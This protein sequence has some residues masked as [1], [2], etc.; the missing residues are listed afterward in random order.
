ME[1]LL[2]FLAFIL[3]IWYLSVRHSFK[4]AEREEEM[5]R[6]NQLNE[7]QYIRK[8]KEKHMLTAQ[9][10]ANK[11]RRAAENKFEEILVK[12]ET[13]YGSETGAPFVETDINHDTLTVSMDGVVIGGIQ[14]A[15]Q[16]VKDAEKKILELM[17]KFPRI[18]E[19]SVNLNGTAINAIMIGDQTVVENLSIELD[20]ITPEMLKA[21]EDHAFRNFKLFI[22][23]ITNG[24]TFYN[25]ALAAQE[26]V[27]YAKQAHADFVHN[28]NAKRTF[29][30]TGE[31]VEY[32]KAEYPWASFTDVKRAIAQAEKEVEL[33]SKQAKKLGYESQAIVVGEEYTIDISAGR[34]ETSHP[35]RTAALRLGLIIESP[36]I[37]IVDEQLDTNDSL[38]SITL[39]T[40][41]QCVAALKPEKNGLGIYVKTF[42]P[43]NYTE[44]FDKYGLEDELWQ[45]DQD[46][47]LQD[48][49]NQ[50]LWK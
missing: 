32:I 5:H 29:Q 50:D 37:F 21:M 10:E 7:I 38:Y 40:G 47:T 42:M 41:Q 11:A 9:Y 33:F 15:R 35:Q 28:S 46:V 36:V 25:A 12:L 22:R 16:L 4:K 19:M 13:E 45:D 8:L 6:Q 1:T 18:P 14:D 48:L 30:E 20:D 43:S 17:P 26:K 27:E 34:T 3:L 24:V 49:I 23:N 2:I 39:S 44:Y 31:Y